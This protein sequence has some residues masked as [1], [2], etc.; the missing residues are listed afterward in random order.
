MRVLFTSISGLGHVH[1]LV[2]L[3]HALLARGHVV[4]WLTGPDATDRLRAAG[5]DADPV[6][7]PFEDLRR[8]LYGRYPDVRVMPPEEAPWF[9]FPH[10]FGEVAPPHVVDDVVRIAREWRPALVIHDAADFTGPIAAASLGVPAV[11]HGF[12]A[13]T[14]PARVIEAAELAAPLWRSHGLEPRPYGGLYDHAYLDPYPASLQTTEFGHVR[15]RLA[16]RPDT[17]DDPSGADIDLYAGGD[18][19]PLVYLTFGTIARGPAALSVA[20]DAIAARPV[21]VLVTVGPDGDPDALGPQPPQVHVERYVPQAPVL[22]HASVVVSHAGSGTFLAAVANG[23]PQLC[24]PQAADQ[25]LNA[26]ACRRS[27]IGLS[28]TPQA[29]AAGSVGAALD[30]LLGETAFRDRAQA[31]AAEIAAMPSPDH[32]SGMLERLAGQG[33]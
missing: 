22:G 1:P 6:G 2:P 18:P 3:A 29:A 7:V 30:R 16:I 33:R 21:R 26:D 27:G 19:R 28:L 17:F 25:F 14:P 9:V 10:L 23:L 12:G 15:N 11:T 24:L 20:L 8:E 13:L 32:V 5:I 4:R 31:V